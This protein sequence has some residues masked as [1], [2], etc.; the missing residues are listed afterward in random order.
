MEILTPK[1]VESLPPYF[2]NVNPTSL[3]Q[4][5]LKQVVSQVG[6]CVSAMDATHCI[7][8]MARKPSLRALSTLFAPICCLKFKNLKV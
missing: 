2:Q 1:V 6:Y 7:A 3:A 5:W 8:C 4:E